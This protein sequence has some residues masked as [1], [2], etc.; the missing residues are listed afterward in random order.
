MQKT[1]LKLFKETKSESTDEHKVAKESV[2]LEALAAMTGFPAKMIKT[3]LF[4]G[5]LNEGEPISL[6]ELRTHMLGFLNR[7]LSKHITDSEAV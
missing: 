6:E 4:L 2:S 1:D 7:S 5:E 3:E